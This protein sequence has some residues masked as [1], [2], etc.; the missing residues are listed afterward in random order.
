MF[1]S[2]TAYQQYSPPVVLREMGHK[3]T[4]CKEEGEK[5]IV[6]REWNKR[7]RKRDINEFDWIRWRADE[8]NM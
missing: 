6:K 7:H 2:C 1:I 3:V 4:E 5:Y 8:E